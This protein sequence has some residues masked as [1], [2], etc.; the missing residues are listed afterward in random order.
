MR[1]GATLTLFLTGAALVIAAT[2]TPMAAHS[3]ATAPCGSDYW[4]LKTFS[5]PLRKKVTSDAEG[6]DVGCDHEPSSPA[7]DAKRRAT[8]RLSFRFGA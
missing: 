5:D 4:P 8:R 3:T 7:A 2:A 1:V 6:H